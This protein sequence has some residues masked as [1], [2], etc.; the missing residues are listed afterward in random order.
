V[1]GLNSDCDGEGRVLFS[2]NDAVGKVSA[3]WKELRINQ[4]TSDSAGSSRY[5]AQASHQTVPE[6]ISTSTPGVAIPVG[7]TDQKVSGHG[8]L[9]LFWGFLHWQ[10]VHAPLAGVLP[11]SARAHD[12]E[13]DPAPADLALS[14]YRR[15]TRRREET[16]ARGASAP[17]CRPG[18]AARD[19]AHRQPVD[20]RPVRSTSFCGWC[21]PSP[22][23]P[24][25]ASRKTRGWA[26][27]WWRSST[28]RSTGSAGRMQSGSRARCL[29]RMWP[30]SGTANK[31]ETASG[32]WCWC[33][34]AWR[35]RNVAPV[36]S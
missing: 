2:R 19:Q 7:F 18:T 15:S 21:G 31:A 20:L 22:V 13:G 12:P 14:F 3:I 10:R 25:C 36:K 9:A 32:G 26:T 34:T 4:K 5:I 1:S 29:E 23:L 6:F 11:I 27:S 30:K 17:R 35:R 24:S 8:G 16:H 33:V 28:P